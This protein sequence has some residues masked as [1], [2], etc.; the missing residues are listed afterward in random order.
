MEE[1]A[2]KPLENL[3]EFEYNYKKEYYPNLL[4]YASL[5]YEKLIFD[6]A[7]GGIVYKVP[8]GKRLFLTSC[9]VTCAGAVN[10]S[11]SSFSI[12]ES[13]MTFAWCSAVAGSQSNMSVSFVMPLVINS[14][15]TITFQVTTSGRGFLYG[16]ISPII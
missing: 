8:E 14:G 6:V 5:N 1:V 12:I 4:D 10:P 16:F 2:F 13:D 11:G 15:E 3:K 9:F 7:V